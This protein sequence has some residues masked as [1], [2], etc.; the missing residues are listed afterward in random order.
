MM[1][2]GNPAML[3]IFLGINPTSIGVAP[4]Q[5]AFYE[6]QWV[7][8]EQLGFEQLTCPVHTLPQISGF[9]GGDILA[10]AIGAEMGQ[11]PAGT[12]LV[13]IG[14]NGELIYKGEHGFYATSCATGPVFEGA[15]LSCGMQAIP[16]AI[17]KVFLAGAT[18]LPE[19]SVIQTSNYDVTM[20]PIGL[21][22]SG[23][24]SA[25]AELYRAGVIDSGG[26][27]AVDDNIV[28]L[29]R[30]QLGM[31][32]YLIAAKGKNQ[33]SKDVVI[34]QKDIRSIQLGKA[35]LITGIEFLLKREGTSVPEQIV[36]A[37]AFGSYLDKED[38]MT[39]GMIPQVPKDRIEIAGNLAGAGAVMALCDKQYLQLAKELAAKIVV[40]EL[41]TSIEFQ[42]VF[43]EKLGFPK[44]L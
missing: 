8:G 41:A 14:T 27:M 25:T 13:D 2:V 1:A 22:G 28:S 30:N 40:I 4:Y 6:A 35:A 29:Q 37:G 39:L 26:A 17:D 21:C 31:K 34:S 23:V 44:P 19:Y 7:E 42:Q 16:G 10:A 43:I 36:V 9:L 3:H 33:K 24:I 5:P 15:S 32:E 11:R 12:L 18:K 20:P 38:M